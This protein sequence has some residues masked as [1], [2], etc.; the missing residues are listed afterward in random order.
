MTYTRV[1][2]EVEALEERLQLVKWTLTAP[3][4]SLRTSFHLKSSVVARTA[5]LLGPRFPRG[6]HFE[7]RLR[8]AWAARRQ[9]AGS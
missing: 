2:H 9:P 3:M 5:A 4:K 8:R 7:R 1:L 6:V